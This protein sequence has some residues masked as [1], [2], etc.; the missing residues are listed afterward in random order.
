MDT[1]INFKDKYNTTFPKEKKIE[2]Q[3]A[4]PIRNAVMHEDHDD[5]C[6]PSDK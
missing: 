4:Y 5:G 1:W 2:K 3:S 6:D